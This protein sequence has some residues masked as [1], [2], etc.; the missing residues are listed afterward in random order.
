VSLGGIIF[1]HPTFSKAH[2]KC[3]NVQAGIC[4]AASRSKINSEPS[5]LLSFA[6]L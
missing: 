4:K 3:L 1:F 5:L 2:K 6:L